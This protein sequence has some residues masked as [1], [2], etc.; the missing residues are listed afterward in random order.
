MDARATPPHGD[1]ARPLTPRQEQVVDCLV[2]GLTYDETAVELEIAVS[3]V[4]DRVDE[5]ANVLPND[6]DLEPEKLVRLWGAWRYWR[7]RFAKHPQIAP[8]GPPITGGMR[9]D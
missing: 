9:A 5:V 2:R 7:Q 6:G 4:K 1:P 8:P 3:T